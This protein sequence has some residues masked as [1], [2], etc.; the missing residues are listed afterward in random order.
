MKNRRSSALQLS[1]RIS[2]LLLLAG[3]FSLPA[4]AAVPDWVHAAAGQPVS[5]VDKD[6]EAIVL[7][8]EQT[9]TVQENGDTTTLYR[10]VMKVLRPQGREH[11]F[12]TIHYDKETKL[13]SVHAWSITPKG[14]EYELKEKDFFE[15]TPYTG[16]LFDDEKL[17]VAVL[18][19]VDAGTVTAIEYEQHDRPYLLQDF[20]LFQETF[21]VKV[22]RY[23]LHLP[24]S[25]EYT[26]NWIHYDQAKP[27]SL[28]GN[29][30]SWEL[31]DIPAIEKEPAMPAQRV[32][33]GRMVLSFHGELK[34]KR[35]VKSVPTWEQVAQFYAGLDADRLIATQEIVQKAKELTAN[36]PDFWSKVS[37]IS[38]FMQRDIR[39]VA[40]EIG[41]GGFQPH[42][43][44]DVFRNRY[45]DCKDKTTLF[46]ALLREA[47]IPATYFHVDFRRG[48]VV[49]EAPAAA[50][51]H[52][53]TAIELPAGFT[54]ESIASTVQARDGKKYLLFDPTDT[55]TPIGQLNAPLQGSY[56]LLAENNGGELLKIPVFAPE[57]NEL[58]R[59]AH[60]KLQP[61]G[62]LSGEVEETRTGSVAWDS[63]SE[64]L[65][66]EQK[67]RTKALD[68][69]LS[70]FLNGVTVSKSAAEHLDDYD[71]SLVIRYSFTAQGYAK[72]AGPLLLVRP[73]VLGEKAM[74]VE[75]NK[76]RKFPLEFDSSEYQSDLF[77]IE[78]PPGFAVDEL[79]DPVKVDVGF[80]SYLS[81]TEVAGQ[82]LRYT[83]EYKVKDLL[84][85][86][87]DENQWKRLFATIYN[88]ERNSAVL[89]KQ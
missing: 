20:W 63:R 52:V 28:G 60:L 74:A 39:Y 26:E 15:T 83:R 2:A 82:T 23:T 88:D 6:T 44:G 62:S 57:K 70:H 13:K 50:F 19:G 35:Q 69:Y 64:L 37:A 65:A 81:K 33:A 47:G 89:K 11:A 10:R 29:Q 80:A 9:T 79:P 42:P 73:R 54:N 27:A 71:Q 7:L 49:P 43:A 46:I 59:V 12:P 45:G 85:P 68:K 56:G 76:P 72:S 48:W 61:D 84:V 32:L 4:A 75:T 51:D 58:K 77:E 14:D 55:F 41:I 86:T 22:A 1:L 78:L 8:D 34:G 36:S 30:W 40:I 17:K 16:S 18:P 53:I 21:P 3:A 31:K 25:W 66:S 67:E 38:R 24:A 87:S 5:G